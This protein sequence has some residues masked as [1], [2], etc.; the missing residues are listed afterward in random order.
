MAILVSLL[1]TSTRATLSAAE[2]PGI[3]APTVEPKM[4]NPGPPPADAIVLFDGRDFGAWQHSDGSPVKWNLVDGAM[5]VVKKAGQIET[6]RAFSSCQ[7]HIEWATPTEVSGN[8]QGRGN[9]GI[10]LMGEY[11][12]QVLDSVDNPT[13]FHGQAGSVYKQHAPLVNASRGPGEWQN[14]DILFHAPQFEGQ[15]VVTPARFTVLHNGVLIQDHVEVLG[16]T[17]NKGMPKYFPHP[18]KAPLRLQ[19]HGNPVRF[20]NIWIREL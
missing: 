4:V 16:R 14:F 7:L 10:F 1:L 11:E 13:Y 20:R 5:E 15:T 6:K 12:I 17:V 8:G 9:S 3:P 18:G 2:E 19:D